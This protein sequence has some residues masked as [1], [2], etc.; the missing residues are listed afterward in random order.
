MNFNRKTFSFILLL[1]T[2]AD[3]VLAMQLDLKIASFK[4]QIEE[5]EIYITSL[6]LQ[7]GFSS[8]SVPSMGPPEQGKIAVLGVLEV[9][10]NAINSDGWSGIDSIDKLIEKWTKNNAIKFGVIQIG[11]L[12][13]NEKN[14][15]STENGALRYDQLVK[16]LQQAKYVTFGTKVYAVETEFEDFLGTFKSALQY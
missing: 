11:R 10:R 1:W 5:N 16:A 3:Q 2:C 14:A 8:I 9:I 13:E 6:K 4:Y 7:P 15:M 12:S